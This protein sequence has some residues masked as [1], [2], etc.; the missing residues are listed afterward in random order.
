MEES[1]HLSNA[2]KVA[3][4][5]SSWMVF[6]TSLSIA[7]NSFSG[8]VFYESNTGINRG[9]LSN[10]YWKSRS[11]DETPSKVLSY[12]DT[13]LKAT[14]KIENFEIFVERAK[15]ATLVTNSNA[16]FAAATSSQILETTKTGSYSI[17]GKVNS[18]GFD[19][20]GLTF[21]NDGE[22]KALTWSLSPKLVRLNSLTTGSGVGQLEVGANSQRLT[23]LVDRQGLTSYGFLTNVD[24]QQ[25]GIGTT[26]DAHLSY[27]I[28]SNKFD[29]DV[30]NL[31]SKIPVNGMFHSER[32]YQVN[33]LNGELIFG[34]VPSMTGT[35]G[36]ENKN[37]RLPQIFKASW[38]S[39]P[40]NSH[41]SEKLGVIS[42]DSNKIIFGELGYK[43][44][45]SSF[46]LKSY[47]LQNLFLTYSKQNFILN[48]LTTD[49]TI[50]SA[51]Q[52]KNQL[53]ITGLRYSF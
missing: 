38:S 23:G 11:L 30:I 41:W 29:L 43:F 17:N 42:F 13:K 48:N 40:M 47:E 45:D 25:I 46:I 5:L 3:N 15:V 1:C 51:F 32:S 31:A 8:E 26:V 2:M 24:S 4:C 36:Q 33:T 53:L 37:L 9:L 22:G 19:A 6:I 44:G 18:Y 7:Q 52:S 10:S 27:N 34:S 28:Q 39:K 49:I 20:A 21:A 14:G 50:G 12:F 16:L 35:Y